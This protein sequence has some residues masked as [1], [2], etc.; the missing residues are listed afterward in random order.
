MLPG[1][2]AV[3]I[4]GTVEGSRHEPTRALVARAS[5]LIGEDQHRRRIATLDVV[6]TEAAKSGQAVAGIGETLEAVNRGAVHRLF[7][8]ATFATA[9]TACESCGVLAQGAAG[10][11][12]GCGRPTRPVALA[13][14]MSE[15]VLAAGGDVEVVDGHARLRDVGGVAAL[16]RYPL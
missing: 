11:C 9:G 5:E 7:V 13:P 12:L 1:R 15:R 6:L 2:I 4:T 8:A 16:L 3:K 14:A 10:A